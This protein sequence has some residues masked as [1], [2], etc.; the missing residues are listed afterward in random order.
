MK[1]NIKSKALLTVLALTLNTSVVFADSKTIKTDMIEYNKTNTAVVNSSIMGLGEGYDVVRKTPN[2]SD[3]IAWFLSVSGTG[4]TVYCLEYG[5]TLK[6]NTSSAYVSDLASFLK[7]ETLANK[8]QEY[9][10]FGYGSN[11]NRK[12]AIYYL[13]TQTLIWQAMNDAGKGNDAL[14]T[15]ANSKY[16]YHYSREGSN[17][18][19]DTAD[20]N[21][22][23][24]I[25]AAKQEILND[26]KNYTI[27]PSFCNSNEKLEIAVDESAT[28]EDKNNVLANYTP[29]CS[30]GIKCEVSG[31]QLK[32]T[33]LSENKEQTITFTKNGDNKGKSLIYKADGQQAVA[34]SVGKVAPVSCQFGVDT[35]KQVQ[36]SDA[37]IVM[38]IMVAFM[39]GA[40]AYV[41][42]YTK[43]SLN[44]V[45]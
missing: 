20:T 15:F 31:N 40:L 25:N 26:I 6:N 44:E 12:T 19:G 36:T 17:N 21:L 18:L 32:V 2:T 29:E 16:Q 7:N 23:N 35:Y 8:I 4:E 9:M 39:C 3:H 41:A 10:Y 45:K 43:K 30:E 37:K 5:L 27:I 11:G 33:A 38:V 13:A 1:K 22:N 28:F 14:K 24:K 34:T 42:Y